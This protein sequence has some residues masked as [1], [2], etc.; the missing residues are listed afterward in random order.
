M[1]TTRN[2]PTGLYSKG[3]RSIEHLVLALLAPS[4]RNMRSPLT[5]KPSRHMLKRLTVHATAYAAS[6][7]HT[8]GPTLLSRIPS[9][10]QGL[11]EQASKQKEGRNRPELYAKPES[12]S[13][14]CTCNYVI[15][16]GPGAMA[17]EM[18]TQRIEQ[19]VLGRPAMR[20]QPRNQQL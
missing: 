18:M 5:M 8:C 6:Q 2:K 19:W 17:I 20:L 16:R 11:Q 15:H 1:P 13:G 4:D 9:S 10:L 7:Q 3:K 14:S 12:L